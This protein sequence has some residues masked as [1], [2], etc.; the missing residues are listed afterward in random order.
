[1]RLRQSAPDQ[2]IIRGIGGFGELRMNFQRVLVGLVILLAAGLAASFYMNWKMLTQL[3]TVKAF[4]EGSVFADAVAACERAQST[5]PFKWNGGKQTAVVGLN[6]VKPN[7][8]TV[9]A[10]YTLVADSVFCDYDPIKKK[11]DIGSNFLERE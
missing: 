9:I 1:M 11:A 7:K 6:S 2:L 3:R 8:D 5:T 4:V 10:S